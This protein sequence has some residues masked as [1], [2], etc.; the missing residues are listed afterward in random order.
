MKVITLASG[1]KGNCTYIQTDKV[2]V[3]VDAGVNLGEIENKLNMLDVNPKDISCIFVTHEH[4][5]HIKSVGAFAR[6]NGSM[7]IANEKE[8]E[9]LEDKLGKLKTTQ[10]VSYS[11]PAF[12]VEDLKVRAYKLSHDSYTCFGYSFS[13]NQNKIAIATDLGYAPTNVVDELKGS[14]LVIL[15]ANHDEKLLLN[16]PKYSI[17]LKKRILSKK[18]HLSNVT[19]SNVISQ[20]VGTGTKQIVLAHLSEE[21]N[22]P[23]LAYNT[24]KNELYKNGIIEGEHIFIDVST[25]HEMGN[26]FNLKNKE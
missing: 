7:V 13:N 8:W 17:S 14:D 9:V 20:L 25:Q 3:L 2:K 19:S 16:N 23:T 10:K 5:D 11:S 21:N 24:V 22:T 26:L 6:K 1:S 18:G 4:S 15:E 12:M